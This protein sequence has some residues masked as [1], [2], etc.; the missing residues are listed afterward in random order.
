VAAGSAE[1]V[2]SVVEAAAA[3]ELVLA[4][5]VVSASVVA[6]GCE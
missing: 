5:E 4:A 2:E 3:A 1:A 6:V